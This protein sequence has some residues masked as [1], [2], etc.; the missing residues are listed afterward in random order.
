MVVLAKADSF[1]KMV[2]L[3]IY[4]TLGGVYENQTYR[5]GDASLKN[6]CHYHFHVFFQ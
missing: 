3:D 2:I 4:V 6:L 5:K 1:R